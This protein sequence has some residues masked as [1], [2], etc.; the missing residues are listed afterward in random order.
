M[1]D[2]KRGCLACVGHVGAIDVVEM[3]RHCWAW[4]WSE[5]PGLRSQLGRCGE[6]GGEMMFGGEVCAVHVCLSVY[7]E[8][9][10]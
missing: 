5:R 6:I 9:R 2:V 1:R 8:V 7:V 4:V 10:R 3:V